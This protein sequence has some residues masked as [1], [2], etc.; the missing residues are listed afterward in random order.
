MRHSVKALLLS[1]LLAS[2][3]A[4][5]AAAPTPPNVR[6][7]ITDFPPQFILAGPRRGNGLAEIAQNIVFARLPGYRH[8]LET[9]PANYPRIE[10][11]LKIHDNVCFAALLKTPERERDFVFSQPYRLL[12]PIQL[13]VPQDRGQPPLQADGTVDLAAL[14]ASGD[15][16]LGVLGGRHYGPGID[17]VLDQHPKDAAVY[18]RYAQDQLDGL[19][20]MMFIDSRAIDGVLAYPNELNDLAT[21]SNKPAP[22]MRHY[23]IAGTPEYLEGYIAC[24]SSPLGRQL[25][26]DIDGIIDEIRRAVSR[27]YAAQLQGA[28]RER[29]E[30]LA[31]RRFGATGAAAAKP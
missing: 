27:A 17:A 13:F 15:F 19:L 22:P 25:V 24:S 7:L 21:A 2:S 20:N 29:Y 5:T 8:R 12:L 16:R 3:G 6:W 18:R 11:E 23:A 28:D 10:H 14:L 30:A 26:A 4:A 9:V 31:E 1:A